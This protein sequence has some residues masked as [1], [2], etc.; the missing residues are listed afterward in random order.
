MENAPFGYSLVDGELVP[1]P[2][3]SKI[4]KV[5]YGLYSMGLSSIEVTTLLDDFKV[6]RQEHNYTNYPIDEKIHE[7]Y[8]AGSKMYLEKVLN[9]IEGSVDELLTHVESNDF[10]ITDFQSVLQGIKNIIQVS[11]VN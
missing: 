11:K 6:P 1:H 9:N 3:E 8:Q 10:E 2:F 5:M 4:V 7:I